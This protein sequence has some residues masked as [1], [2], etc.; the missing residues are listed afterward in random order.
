[1][2]TF[3]L[4]GSTSTSASSAASI[5]ATRSAVDGFI[6]APPST[7]TRPEALEQRAGSPRPPRP[8]RPRRRAA[9]RARLGDRLQQARLALRRLLV[10]VRDLDA[11]DRALRDAQRQRGSRIVR[12][13]VHLQGGAV[14]DHEQRVAEQ[15]ELALERIRVEVASPSTMNTVQ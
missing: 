12:V 5:A 10:H 4:F 14:A 6:V 13:H 1:M 2:I 8:R 9:A 7:T 15:L 3:P 11:R